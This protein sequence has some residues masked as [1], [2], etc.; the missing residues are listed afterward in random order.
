[1]AHGPGVSSEAGEPVA[2]EEPAV[3]GVPSVSAGGCRP[4][5]RASAVSSA[6]D[7]SGAYDIH[8]PG[9]SA[10]SRKSTGRI[11]CAESIAV[12]AVVVGAYTVRPVRLATCWATESPPCV[13]AA[14]VAQAYSTMGRSFGPRSAK[15][16]R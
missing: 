7:G 9:F 13:G 8:W 6:P 12:P 2:V 16:S 4:A 14:P 11:C 5:A 3:S 1:M 10:L 15:C